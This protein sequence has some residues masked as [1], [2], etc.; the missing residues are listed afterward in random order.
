MK[1]MSMVGESITINCMAA[2]NKF[3]EKRKGF[4]NAPPFA[5]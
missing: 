5:S 2:T 1:V 4:V 3:S